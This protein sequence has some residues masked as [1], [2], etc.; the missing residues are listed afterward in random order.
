V[1]EVVNGNIPADAEEEVIRLTCQAMVVDLM[2]T[3]PDNAEDLEASDLME[4]VPKPWREK[5]SATVRVRGYTEHAAPCI[6]ATQHNRDLLGAKPV[7]TL[8]TVVTCFSRMPKLP[9]VRGNATSAIFLH[10]QKWAEKVLKHYQK[11]KDDEKRTYAEIE[12]DEIQVMYVDAV[13]D[14]PLYGTCFFHVRKNSFPEHMDSYPENSII[15]LNYEGLHFLNEERETL[16]SYGYADIYRW[17]GSST[18]F[19]IIIWNAELQDTENV[20]MFTS[21]A[22]DMAALILDYINAI[23]AANE[24]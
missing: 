5:R 13:R 4:Y 12:P 20:T 3:F 22:A 7:A 6:N 17:G 18:Q 21:Q 15:A 24:S 11:F 2:D 1:D 19:S 23:M 8:P 16:A 14:H 9:C 10:M